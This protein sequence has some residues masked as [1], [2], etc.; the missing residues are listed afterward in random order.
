M[1]ITD[2]VNRMMKEVI[3]DREYVIEWVALKL[4]KALDGKTF[5]E[6]VEILE[7]AYDS[8][9][10]QEYDRLPITARQHDEWTQP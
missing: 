10:I 4:F 1:P 9:L 6:I 2:G 5:A 3:Y 7:E 8:L